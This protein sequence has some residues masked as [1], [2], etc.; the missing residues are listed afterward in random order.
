[1]QLPGKKRREGGGKNV[2]IPKPKEV[3][4]KKEEPSEVKEK[5]ES[6]RG[7]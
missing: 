1:M 3:R 7:L 6:C 5:D 4:G 2:K